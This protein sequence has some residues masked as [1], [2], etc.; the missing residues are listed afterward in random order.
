[1]PFAPSPVMPFMA[2]KWENGLPTENVVLEN[3]VHVW[4]Y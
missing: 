4:N 1:M 3:A 2:G